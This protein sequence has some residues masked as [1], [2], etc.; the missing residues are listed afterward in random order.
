[1]KTTIIIDF[2]FSYTTLRVIS[3]SRVYLTNKV[4]FLYN[5]II[6]C[7]MSNHIPPYVGMNTTTFIRS[8]YYYHY[9]RT[10][11]D[12]GTKKLFNQLNFNI[13]I[14]DFLSNKYFHFLIMYGS[15][16]V[17]MMMVRI[18]TERTPLYNFAFFLPCVDVM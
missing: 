16:E 9:Y 17:R 18:S 2:L 15:N 4:L 8:L 3:K 14:E 6:I 13:N 5:S 10:L 11:S 12:Q 7:T 1:M